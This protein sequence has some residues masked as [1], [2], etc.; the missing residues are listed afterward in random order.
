[1]F[2]KI[3]IANRGEIACR[4]IKT[5]R[6]MGIQTVAV[7][8]EAD[9]DALHVRMADEAVLIGPPAAAES[10]LVA[11]K[12]V[13]AAK[14]TGA[15]AIHPGYG[16]LS[17]NAGFAERLEKEGIAFIGPNVKAIQ[18]MGDKIESKK[19]ANEAKVNTVP[20]Y[21]GVIQSPEEAIKIAGEIGY[22]VMIKASAGGGGKGMRVAWTEDDVA[23]GFVSSMNEAR[24]SFGDDRVFIEKFITEPRHIEIQVLADKHG[25]VIYAGEREC[26]V[27]RRNQKVI[28]EAPS[29][30]LDEA[31]RKEMGEQAVALAKAVDYESAGTVE[32][33]VDGARNFYFLEMNT[34][35]QVEHPVTELVTGIDLVEQMIRVAAGEKL[36][37]K[38]EDVKLKGWAIESRIYAEDPYRNFLP[39]IGRLVR[40]RPPAEACEGGLTIR[41]DTGVEEGSEISLFYDPMIA[42]L[43]THGPDRLSAIDHMMLALDSFWIDGIEQNIPFLSAV[44][45]QD[46][47][48]EG[49]L[50]TGYIDEEFPD[51]FDGAP[52]TEEILYKLTAVAVFAEARLGQRNR[53][54][55]DVN[56]A[57]DLSAPVH[58][59][60]LGGE[61]PLNVTYAAEGDGLRVCSLDGGPKDFTLFSD[62]HLGESLIRIRINDDVMAV[63]VTRQLD[64][65]EL[66]YR[67][68]VIVLA[69][70]RP[71]VAEL[72]ALMPE[73]VVPDT[74]N[75]L[76][77]PMPGLVISVDVEEG[78]QVKAGSPVAVVEAM[79]MEN[80][81]RAERDCIVKKIHAAPGDSLAVDEIIV[82]YEQTA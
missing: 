38:Q 21:L 19:F 5:A 56:L 33:I 65:W 12:I 11:D 8:S 53:A 77:C 50:T 26:S 28:E 29:P 27:Q 60:V 17:E 41:N 73:R 24:S 51:G 35:L 31:T 75:L 74:S 55:L 59:V 62:W 6:K 7:Y 46:R 54:H 32:F 22:P 82:E 48:R 1:M 4:V 2:K 30:F 57:E 14:D 45:G 66:S 34:R 79:K 76:L 42:K 78:Q 69:V 71:D 44:Y 10:Y 49:R 61:K 64:G 72:A 25:H 39:S 37:L 68:A 70:L 67:G 15:E 80:I 81:L 9:A 36:S 63:R 40:Y 13:Q 3:L 58:R 47:F 18:V 20:G 23:E 16:F 43:C 52:I